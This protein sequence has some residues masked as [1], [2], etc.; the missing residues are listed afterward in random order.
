MGSLV[1]KLLTLYALYNLTGPGL[2]VIF[3][4]LGGFYIGASWG[5]FAL[6]V[7]VGVLLFIAHFIILQL[8][9][10][11]RKNKFFGDFHQS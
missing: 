6:L 5:W 7:Y 1:G 11:I 3:V 2:I 4:S 8:A 9:K 10:M